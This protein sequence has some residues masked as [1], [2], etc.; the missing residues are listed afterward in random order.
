LQ[1]A[2]SF[3][4]RYIIRSA[5]YHGRHE[6]STALLFFAVKLRTDMAKAFM[7]IA[8]ERFRDDELSETKD[9][10]EKSVN[11]AIIACVKRS[12]CFT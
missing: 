10:L 7:L 4:E 11:T 8:A 3:T 1:Q 12:N 5:I 2:I 9:E 6:E